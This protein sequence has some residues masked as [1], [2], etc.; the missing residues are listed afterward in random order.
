[1]TDTETTYTCTHCAGSGWDPPS[2]E[3]MADTSKDT[4]PHRCRVCAGR[5]V[6]DDALM[7]TR[8]RQAANRIVAQRTLDDVC[9]QGRR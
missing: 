4:G 9:G 2:R 5:G 7:G 3:A 6:T 8:W 1:M